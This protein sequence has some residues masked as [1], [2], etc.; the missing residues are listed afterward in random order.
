MTVD[1]PGASLS[2]GCGFGYGSLIGSHVV[3]VG[4]TQLV[5]RGGVLGAKVRMG[6]VGMFGKHAGS[7][8][9]WMYTLTNGCAQAYDVMLGWMAKQCTH[10][11]C[12][13]SNTLE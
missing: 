9:G 12:A 7:A 13:M 11:T 8:A 3:A 4:S 6:N 2:C 1:S 10:G 5:I